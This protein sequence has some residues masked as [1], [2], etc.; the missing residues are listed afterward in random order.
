MVN[1]SEIL[2]RIKFHALMLGNVT[3]PTRLLVL[4]ELLLDA[5]INH[6]CDFWWKLKRLGF[7]Y[8]ILFVNEVLPIEHMLNMTF[9][10]FRHF[11]EKLLVFFL[12]SKD[13]IVFY[14]RLILIIVLVALD[15]ARLGMIHNPVIGISEFRM[16]LRVI[17]LS[18]FWQRRVIE[19]A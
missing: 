7:L 19:S 9:L 13:I 6:I 16:S 18:Q 2:C 3:S 11:F 5:L 1:K 17:G 8:A 12:C 14:E 10:T 4:L 15:K